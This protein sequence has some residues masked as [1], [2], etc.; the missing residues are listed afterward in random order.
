MVHLALLR[1]VNVGG[2]NRLPMKDLAAIFEKAGCKGVRTYIQS[3]NVVFEA[4]AAVARRCSTLVPEQIRECFGFESPVIVRSKEDLRSVWTGNP[5]LL[6]GSPEETLHVYF[7]DALPEHQR[8]AD[9]DPK[10]SSVDSFLVRGRE[11]YVQCPNGLGNTKL[12]NAWFDSKLKT[13]STCRNWRTVRTLLE[14]ME[15]A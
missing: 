1:G 3:G 9:L 8:V 12:S 7:L 5:F 15:S 4:P 13:V 6:Q 10:R 2:R 14:M 11:V